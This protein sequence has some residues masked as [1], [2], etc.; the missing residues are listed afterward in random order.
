MN[1]SAEA[2]SGDRQAS[3]SALLIG[4]AAAFTL[5][6]YECVRSVSNSVFVQVY[7]ASNLPYVMALAPVVTLLMV[8]AYGSILSRIGARRT[9]VVTTVLSAGVFLLIYGG[10]VSGARV[11][12]VVLYVFREAYIVLL[13]EQYWSFINSTLNARLASRLNGP[14]CGVASAGAIAGGVFVSQAAASMGTNNLLP[15]AAVALIPAAVL[16]WTAYRKG[17]EPAA[18]P[19]HHGSS[20]GLSAFRS[21]PT[22]SW[23]A[24]VI[25]LTQVLAAVLDLAFNHA[26]AEAIPDTD[27]RTAFYGQFFASLNGGAFVLQFVG[28]PLLLRYVSLRKIHF[29]MPVVHAAAAMALLFV[30]GLAVAGAAFFLFKA[31]DY[32]IFRAAKEMLYIPMSYDAR[33][34]AKEIIDAF[35][36]RAGKGLASGTI[37][38]AGLLIA[39]MS[40]IAFPLS[41]IAACAGWLVSARRLIDHSST[42]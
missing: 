9:L 10:L 26:V 21:N 20:L 1:A 15:V 11:S 40:G 33:Y 3:I 14:I 7:G 37:A 25:L 39:P 17:G 29:G 35:G 23:I 27:T 2:P 28:A 18:P 19:D 42:R 30:P 24:A 13:I 4:C 8:W 16:S 32:S 12:A 38:A 34:R 41:A 6:G 31:V 22:L 36:Y 5:G